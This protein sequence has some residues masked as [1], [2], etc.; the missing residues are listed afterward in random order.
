MLPGSQLMRLPQPPPSCLRS[1]GRPLPYTSALGTKVGQ[2]SGACAVWTEPRQGQ[3][4]GQG[5]HGMG[6]RGRQGQRWSPGPESGVLVNPSTQQSPELVWDRGCTAAFSAP[7]A[8]WA[9]AQVKDPC[10]AGCE[11]QG[12]WHPPRPGQSRLLQG[13]VTVARN[14]SLPPTS[15]SPS[16]GTVGTLLPVTSAAAARSAGCSEAAVTGPLFSWPQGLGKSLFSTFSTNTT[17]K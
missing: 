9:G 1:L 13:N 5:G 11:S 17:T 10:P 12:A 8:P 2:L 7:C 14:L 16:P 3:R 6:S 15:A 4:L